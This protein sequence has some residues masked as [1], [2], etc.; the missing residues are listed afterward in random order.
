[1]VDGGGV[2]TGEVW[3]V[4]YG[5]GVRGR[6]CIRQVFR[7]K[8]TNPNGVVVGLFEDVGV[9]SGANQRELYRF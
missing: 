8:E 5:G 4:H 1:M 9:V 2:I 3:A 6:A 7:P